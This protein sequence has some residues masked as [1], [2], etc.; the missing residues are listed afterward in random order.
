M[1]NYY[2]FAVLFLGFLFFSFSSENN[3]EI[4][5]KQEISKAKI[6]PQ[7]ANL[8][9]SKKQK[10]SLKERFALKLIKKKIKKNI[11][12][13]R[14]EPNSEKSSFAI[15]FLSLL[16]VLMAIAGVVAGIIYLALGN[17]LA[18]VLLILGGLLLI[19]LFVI[20]YFIIAILTWEV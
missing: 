7:K 15:D 12:K 18:G 6:S 8:A 19:P 17:I 4:L 20:F 11:T 1:K 5:P 16:I 10:T 2:L 9:Q 13:N 3:S 14:E